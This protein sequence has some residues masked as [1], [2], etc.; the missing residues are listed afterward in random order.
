MAYDEIIKELKSK[1]GDSPEENESFLKKETERFVREKNY[2]GIEAAGELILQNMSDE[3]R[4]E[5]TRLTHVDGVRLDALY[6]N[7]SKLINE[8]KMVEAKPLAERLYK[9]I[10]VEYRE[11]ENAKFVSLR[12]PFEDN[13]YQLM[14]KPEKKLNR[15]PFDFATMLTTY[16]YI[17]IETGSPLDAMP[18]LNEAIE[19]NPVDCGPK[20]ELAEV[21]KL[22]KNK[23]RLFEITRDTLKIASSPIS[24]ARCYA[25]LGYILTDVQE[26]E[27]AAA[28]YTASIM[29]APNPAIP[30]EMRHIADLK[31][32]P[33]ATPDH[34]HIMEVM[35]KYDIEFGPNQDVISVAAQLSSHYLARKDIPNALMA[36]KLTYNLTLDP[37]IK[38][39]IIKYEPNAPQLVPSPQETENNDEKA[40]NIT[41]TVN[42][43]PEK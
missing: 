39:L 25:N 14:F 19:F 38:E 13:L 2:E 42:E 8:H 43:N 6:E 31:G 28:F 22:L 17:L 18:I 10:S 29:F 20:F 12:N 4:E 15:S 33:I 23:Q 5:I 3:K 1:L 11:S 37:K 35:K 9:K 26:Y 34:K 7:I 41:R 24:I 32:S 27:D 36:M 16:A 30:H 40:N 21:Y